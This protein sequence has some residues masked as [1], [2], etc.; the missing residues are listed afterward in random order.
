[1]NNGGGGGAPGQEVHDAGQ[2]QEGRLVL[3]HNVLNVI[4]EGVEWA[5]RG[6]EGDMI[7]MRRR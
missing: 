4:G 7:W 1:M 5:T 2:Q 3:G 6:R